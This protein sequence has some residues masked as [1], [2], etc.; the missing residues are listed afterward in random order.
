[1]IYGKSIFIDMCGNPVTTDMKMGDVT[2]LTSP[3]YPGLTIAEE[4]TTCIWLFTSP[5]PGH[6]EVS[7]TAVDVWDLYVGIGH[8]FG[9]E[10]IV[11]KYEWFILNTLTISDPVMW[12]KYSMW[13]DWTDLGFHLKIKRAPGTGKLKN[14]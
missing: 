9:S 4:D 12:V 10:N 11:G 7:V 2:Y 8:N 5:D 6:Y 14:G 13:A 1:M 3:H